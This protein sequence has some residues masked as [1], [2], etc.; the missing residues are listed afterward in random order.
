M[1]FLAS[2][3]S[4]GL[5]VPALLAGA[6]TV[7]LAAMAACS[8]NS[9]RKLRSALAEQAYTD[10]LIENLSE[11]IYR[12]TPDGQQVRANAAL[13]RLNGYSSEAEMLASVGDIGTEWYVDPD[14]RDEFRRLLER[15]GRVE[16]FVSEIYR[17]KTRERIWIS[18]SARLVRD[19]ATNAPK[20]YEGSVRD[21]TE[22][23]RRLQ[24]EELFSKLIKEVPGAFFQIAILTTG[25]YEISY[26][27]AGFQNITGISQQELAS[28]GSL[29]ISA[30]HPDDRAGYHEHFRNVENPTAFDFESRLITAYGSERWV[31]VSATPQMQPDRVVWHGYMSDITLRKSN[32][33][34]VKQLAY[35]DTLT[36]L[37]NRRALQEQLSEAVARAASVGDHGAALFIDLDNFKSLNDTRGHDI[38]DAYLVQVAERLRSAIGQNGLVARIGGD[39]FVVILQHLSPNADVAGNLAAELGRKINSEMRRPFALGSASHRASASIGVVVF[40][41]TSQ[42][43][44]DI[45][46]SADM[47]MY[48]AKGA[49]RN[50]LSMFN[51]VTTQRETERFM[52]LSDLR[53]ALSRGS[54][55]LELHFQPLVGRDGQ[56]TSAEALMRWR[57]PRLGM[58]YPDRFIPLAEQFGMGQQMGGHTLRAGVRTLAR[59]AADPALADLCLSVNVSFQCLQSDRIVSFVRQLLEEYGIDGNRLTMEVTEHVM[60]QNQPEVG[61]RMSELKMLGVRMSLDDFGTGYSSLTYLK[62]LP[63]D[64]VKI[65]G[66]FV[67]DIESGESGRALV[68]AVLGLAQTLG[69]D[70]VAERVETFAQEE[71]LREHG[72]SIFQ[73][74]LYAKAMPAEEFGTFIRV[75]KPAA[76][77]QMRMA[78]SA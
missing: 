35:F 60:A 59:W 38:G 62:D 40:D 20:Y 36:G 71:F 37:P 31:R 27:S 25:G 41:G 54:D 66:S 76:A 48:E 43:P 77:R 34:A 2:A 53:E 17:H 69:L 32:E 28:D 11:G 3:F 64:E 55:E 68:K 5:S 57:H 4:E 61:R 58:V 1:T 12:S 56:V 29:F 78:I 50:G 15:D 67:A 26:L 70:C 44:E 74:W 10:E 63:F 19:G 8:W 21:I 72:C 39:E 30:V 23:V 73:G 7:A 49:G 14:R 18:E 75:L 65:D 24:L 6:G 46:K 16:D 13:V 51:P 42:T 9:R 22:T 33:L 45:L 47:A 52:L